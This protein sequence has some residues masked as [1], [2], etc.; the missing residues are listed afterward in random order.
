MSYLNFTQT[1]DNPEPEIWDE[2]YSPTDEQW[3]EWIT[4]CTEDKNKT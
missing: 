4:E 3:I 2:K 1:S